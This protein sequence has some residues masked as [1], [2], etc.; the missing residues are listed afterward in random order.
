[1][2]SYTVIH[3]I[4]IWRFGRPFIFFN[5]PWSTVFQ[6]ALNGTAGMWCGSISLKNIYFIE[7][8]STKVNS[9]C[10][11]KL[12]DEGLLPDCR[13][14]YQNVDCVFSARWSH[15]TYT[16]IRDQRLSIDMLAYRHILTVLACFVYKH[17]RSN[18]INSFQ[19]R[20]RNYPTY[21]YWTYLFV[22]WCQ[23]SIFLYFQIRQLW[24]FSFD[25]WLRICKSAERD[26]LASSLYHD[27]QSSIA[28]GARTWTHHLFSTSTYHFNFYLSKLSQWNFYSCMTLCFYCNDT[29][30]TL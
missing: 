29:L 2:S 26:H 16:P 20:F 27:K 24:F 11:M 8:K 23:H 18:Y 28:V 10:H 4:A 3:G 6:I 14:M 21:Y 5:E 22:N 12:L 19:T 13:R 25:N 9:E 30:R 1:M 7:T 15:I 17:K